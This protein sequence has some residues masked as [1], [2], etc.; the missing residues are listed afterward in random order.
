MHHE[1]IVAARTKS[2]VPFA[3]YNNTTSFI[4]AARYGRKMPPCLL[5]GRELIMGTRSQMG[6]HGTPQNFASNISS[7][8]NS[9]SSGVS[10]T[11]NS[12]RPIFPNRRSLRYLPY[13]ER[14]NRMNNSSIIGNFNPRPSVNMNEVQFHSHVTKEREIER[15]AVDIQD[16][17]AWTRPPINFTL[18]DGYYEGA[19]SQKKE[20]LLFKDEKINAMPTNSN[21][22]TY[23]ANDNEENLDLS[24]HLY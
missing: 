10:S 12:S 5:N 6:S 18:L 13:R 8:Q 3:S 4:A 9:I 2:M 16:T 22:E 20:L 11:P 24:L 17:D 1:N 21:V 7:T 14:L 15:H 19:F 23:D